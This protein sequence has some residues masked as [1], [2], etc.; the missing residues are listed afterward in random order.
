MTKILLVGL[1]VDFCFFCY[2][3]ETYNIHLSCCISTFYTH[4]PSMTLTKKLLAARL[5][6][7][8]AHRVQTERIVIST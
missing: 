7:Y 3:I 1:F 2:P 4:A 6:I 8:L 5:P